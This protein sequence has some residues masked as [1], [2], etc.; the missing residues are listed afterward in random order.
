[1]KN[2]KPLEI[3]YESTLPLENELK[4]FLKIIDGAEIYKAN[5]DEGIDVIKILQV[6]SNSLGLN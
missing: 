3:D 2:K 1:M 4:Y 6:A 5:I